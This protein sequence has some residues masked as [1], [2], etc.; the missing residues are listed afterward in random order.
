MSSME[1]L[2]AAVAG[3]KTQEE[4]FT[5]MRQHIVKVLGAG[6]A[7]IQKY[8]EDPRRWRAVQMMV[9]ASKDLANEDGTPKQMLEGVTWEPATM[10]AWR[11][12]LRCP[13]CC[14]RNGP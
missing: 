13:R 11:K 6:T 8:P 1:G 10:V 9:T 5:A 7:F 3:K 2:M 4:R 14:G 12:Q